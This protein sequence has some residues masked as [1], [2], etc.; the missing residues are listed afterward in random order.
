MELWV[1]LLLHLEKKK[2]IKINQDKTEKPLTLHYRQFLA[3]LQCNSIETLNHL[4]STIFCRCYDV[5]YGC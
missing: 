5:T 2:K 4:A 1:N 3:D